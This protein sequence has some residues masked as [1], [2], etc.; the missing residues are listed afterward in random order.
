MTRKDDVLIICAEV[1]KLEAVTAYICRRA[2]ALGA[3]TLLLPKFELVAE[4]LFLNIVNHAV[5]KTCEEVEIRC[6]RQIIAGGD[7]EMCCISM[8]DW[9]PPF[10]PLD[11][12]NPALEQ[13][14]ESRPIGGLGVYLVTQM[15]DHCSYARENGSNLFTICF[16]LPDK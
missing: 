13:D 7:G 14:I 11:K 6:V 16:H 8:R 9:G 2:N 4:E 15:A 3:P 12:E 5:P 10:N 1:N